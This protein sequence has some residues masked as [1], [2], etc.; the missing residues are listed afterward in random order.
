MKQEKA[1]IMALTY[2]IG[3]LTAYIAFGIHS[4]EVEENYPK[5]ITNETT[6]VRTDILSDGF[7]AVLD[8]QYRA[9]SA[10]AYNATEPTPGQHVSI[11]HVTISPD[12][13]YIHYCAKETQEATQCLNYVYA[14]DG[15]ITRVVRDIED[16]PMYSAFDDETYWTAGGY[17]HLAE[18]SS[19]DNKSP[20]L[21][22]SK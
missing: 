21:V 3:F 5:N 12:N 6:D 13:Q 8:G 22:T 17:L 1:I 18:H 15:D 9:L 10:Q 20:W 11:S 2:L 4:P 7:F 14:V 19:I 16:K